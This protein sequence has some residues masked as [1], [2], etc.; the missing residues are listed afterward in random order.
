[1]PGTMSRHEQPEAAE[2]G[3]PPCGE[4][5]RPTEPLPAVDAHDTPAGGTDQ[6]PNKRHSASSTVQLHPLDATS[7]CLEGVG[8]M[9]Q[10]GRLAAPVRSHERG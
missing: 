10:Q 9:P 7:A 6:G 2:S 3:E 1:M 5:P 8:E 4:S